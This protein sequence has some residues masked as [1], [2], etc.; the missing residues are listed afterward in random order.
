MTKYQ[1]DP[2]KIYQLQ[3]WLTNAFGQNA[4]AVSW[5]NYPVIV[6]DSVQSLNDRAHTTN[7]TV[8]LSIIDELIWQ[9]CVQPTLHLSQ[10]TTSTQQ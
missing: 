2:R 4:A 1:L 10:V 3:T 5:V 9:V 8:D 7:V 6:L